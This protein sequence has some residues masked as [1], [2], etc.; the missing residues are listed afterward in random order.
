VRVDIERVHAFRSVDSDA[1]DPGH[2]RLDQFGDSGPRP[3]LSEFR[4]GGRPVV[5]Q[6]K[7]RH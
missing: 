4:A 5:E 2:L 7:D 6:V 1:G 3:G